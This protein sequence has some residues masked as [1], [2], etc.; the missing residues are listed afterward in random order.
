MC[1]WCV[2][3][4]LCGKDSSEAQ[5]VGS[6]LARSYSLFVAVGG[7]SNDLVLAQNAPSGGDICK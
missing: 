2:N 4:R 3:S 5:I 6:L 1:T 7:Y